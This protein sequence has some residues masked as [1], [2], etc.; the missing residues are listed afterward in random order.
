MKKIILLIAA[1]IALNSANAQSVQ[2]RLVTTKNAVTV[3]YKADKPLKLDAIIFSL[4]NAN[5]L[6][7]NSQALP[8]ETFN[9]NNAG[10]NIQSFVHNNWNGVALNGGT[11]WQN[12]VTLNGANT[13]NISLM[14]E[15]TTSSYADATINLQTA[16]WVAYYEKESIKE[17][18]P[19]IT[20][21]LS[22]ASSN[23]VYPN[24]SNKFINIANATADAVIYDLRGN[25]MF[26][27]SLQDM[28]APINIER[29]NAGLY[30]I[31]FM[32]ENKSVNFIK[33]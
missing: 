27:L 18:V 25:I 13:K 23:N 14:Q 10:S 32:G 16:P 1:A 12:L 31:K 30:T 22:I 15:N 7:I 17:L 3:Q 26:K 5:N 11:D 28:N 4:N 21:S 6:K 20:E 2:L 19:S 33:Q 9:Y 8:F 24:P 29:L